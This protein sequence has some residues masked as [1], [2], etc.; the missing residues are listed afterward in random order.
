MR[1]LS[2][3]SEKELPILVSSIVQVMQD[4]NEEITTAKVYN[5]V[6]LIDDLLQIMANRILLRPTFTKTGRKRKDLTL[7]QILAKRIDQHIKNDA[8]Y[9]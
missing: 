7:T 6:I 8:T 2:N 3:I 1:E 5:E 4:N 9:R